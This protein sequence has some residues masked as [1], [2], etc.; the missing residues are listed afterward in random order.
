MGLIINKPIDQKHL[1]KINLEGRLSKLNQKLQ[2]YFGGPVS[3][4]MGFVLHDNKYKTKHTVK[5]SKSISLT[6]NDKI[7][8][9]LKNGE[10]PEK[11]KFS[12]GYSG[13]SRG[14]LDEEIQ[15]GDWI[16]LPAKSNLIFD[17]CESKK[18]ENITKQY[19]FN[20][21]DLTGFSG[22]A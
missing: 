8:E 20:F 15:A 17:L 18:W 16:V 2:L 19:G 14:Q 10:G 4:D 1:K 3:M 7:I 9:D 6:S 13:W 11:F 12:I 22:S 5:L 21:K